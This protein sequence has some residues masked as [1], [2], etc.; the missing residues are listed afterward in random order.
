[1]HM[2]GIHAQKSK[3]NMGVNKRY[4]RENQKWV[5]TMIQIQYYNDIR[6]YGT[7]ERFTNTDDLKIERYSRK[8][9]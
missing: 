8:I 6:K 9:I 3:K 2:T 7:Q 5:V 1:M 4:G